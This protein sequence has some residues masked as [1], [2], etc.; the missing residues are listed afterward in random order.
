VEYLEKEYCV[1][2]ER[3]CKKI[4]EC[5]TEIHHGDAHQHASLYTTLS[6]KLAEQAMAYL[7]IRRESLVP[8]LEDLTMKAEAGHDCRSCTSTCSVRHTM[9][10]LEIKELHGQL[11]LTL[12]ALRS[13]SEPMAHEGQQPDWEQALRKQVKK[14]DEVLSDL[15]FLEE[16]ALLPK[17][18]LTQE[19][20]HAHG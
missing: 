14:L 3:L 9:Q 10:I 6:A 20:I 11:H 18:V 8:Y 15:L 7:S 2:V 19:A 17:V 13:I 16:T 4:T 1:P 5:I 12:E